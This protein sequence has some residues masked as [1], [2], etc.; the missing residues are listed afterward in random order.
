[1]R[2]PSRRDIHDLTRLRIPRCRFGFGISRF[3]NP[4]PPDLDAMTGD[5]LFAHRRE[6]TVD[7][8]GSQAPLAVG[9]FSEDASQVSFR[10][11]SQNVPPD[12]EF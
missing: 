8:P 12:P 10:N 1:M 2:L 6:Q 9:A 4:E 5:E 3:E 11:G 7:N